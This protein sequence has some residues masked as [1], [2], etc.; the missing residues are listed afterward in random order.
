MEHAS[1]LLIASD[2]GIKLTR[3]RAFVQVD[4]VLAQRVVR[5][6]GRLARHSVAF[7]QLV[8]GRAQLLLGHARI[9][10]HLRGVAPLGEERQDDMLQRHVLVAHLA[11]IIHGLLQHRVCLAAEVRFAPLH[12]WVGSDLSIQRRV[13][14][15][16][17][18]A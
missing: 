8:D 1:D 3:P 15:L 12:L 9:L 4:G 6:L 14:P 10:E 5:I 2:H 13:Q 16:Q 11:A 18:D 7:P 17:V